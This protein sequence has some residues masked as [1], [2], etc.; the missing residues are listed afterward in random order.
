M[1]KSHMLHLDGAMLVRNGNIIL[2]PL[3][4]EM[5]TNG[6]TCLL[7]AN[8]AGKSVFLNLCHGMFPP[9]KGE[10]RWG[11]KCA[12]DSRS[13]RSF[14]FQS[15]AIM[16]RSVR[17]NIEYPLIAAGVGRFE[18][19]RKVDEALEFGRLTDRA[20]QPAASL[21]GGEK[22]RMALARALVTKPKVVLLDEPAANL[23]PASTRALESMLH[24]VA[25]NSG[26]MIATH[27]LPQARRL[28][29][30]VLAFSNGQIMASQPADQFFTEHQE[31]TI[32]DYLEGRI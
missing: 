27:D 16:R 2:G 22:Q 17:A 30:H 20:A 8:G 5:N 23:D 28:A 4:L 10:V 26:V 14:M 1:S 3:D 11:D 31:H 18:R 15:A 6:I 25:I 32:S 7:G 19:R 21:S 9:D 24:A 13:E 29:H 12:I